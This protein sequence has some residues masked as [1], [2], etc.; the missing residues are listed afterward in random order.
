MRSTDKFFIPVMAVC[1]L[2]ILAF[3]YMWNKNSVTVAPEESV[4]L[5]DSGI[6]SIGIQVQEL[7]PAL[8]SAFKM[9]KAEG[10]VITELSD[11][12]SV[13][14]SGLKV[15]DVIVEMNK[16]K[17]KNYGDYALALKG[18]KEGS[19]IGIDAI[20]KGARK[21]AVIDLSIDSK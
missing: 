18:I 13:A 20:R 11:R 16:R 6:V 17:I 21:R 9:R 3:G 1:L 5:Q 2:A 12:K 8:V 4:G 19:K 10:V 15:K 14:R 7:N